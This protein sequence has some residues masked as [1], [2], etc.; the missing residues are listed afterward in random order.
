MWLGVW[1][2]RRPR[3]KGNPVRMLAGGVGQDEEVLDT[4]QLR[5]QGTGVREMVTADA[6]LAICIPASLQNPDIS[7]VFRPETILSA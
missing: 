3:A 6:S 2:F 4:Q 1:R 7:Y 5:V